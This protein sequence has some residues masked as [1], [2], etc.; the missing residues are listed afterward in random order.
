M[1]LELFFEVSHT[2]SCY[3]SKKEANRSTTN[4][5]IKTK[6]RKV[7]HGCQFGFEE[8]MLCKAGRLF[9]ASVVGKKRV[10]LLYLDKKLFL[11]HLTKA[12]IMAYKAHCLDYTN[13]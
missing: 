5:V 7:G 4:I 2:R 9:R 3:I 8:I 10:E 12:D 11:K 13:F 6:V 1:Q